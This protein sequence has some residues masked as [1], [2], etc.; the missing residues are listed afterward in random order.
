MQPKRVGAVAAF[1]AAMLAGGEAVAQV[2]AIGGPRP[3]PA[4]CEDFSPTGRGTWVPNSPI[5]VNGDI[6]LGTGIVIG[7]DDV[8]GGYRIVQWLD[9]HCP[10]AAQRQQGPFAG[11]CGGWNGRCE[12]GRVIGLP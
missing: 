11:H 6:I 2:V 3:V 5:L 7:P 9:Q 12:G 1:L 10:S 8:I 4:G